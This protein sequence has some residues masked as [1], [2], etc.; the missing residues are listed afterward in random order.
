MFKEMV[1]HRDS[2]KQKVNMVHDLKEI[3]VHLPPM[4][5]VKGGGKSRNVVRCA[6]NEPNIYISPRHVLMSR[7]HL[8]G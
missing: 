2:C 3:A 1:V 5:G 4:A 6:D 8:Q 7:L